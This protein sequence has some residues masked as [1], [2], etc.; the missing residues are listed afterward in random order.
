[1]S[2][3]KAGGFIQEVGLV[4]EHGPTLWDKYDVEN[5]AAEYEKEAVEWMTKF[6]EAHTFINRVMF[7]FDD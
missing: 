4:S 6:F 3:N 5:F 7:V 1:M 2:W